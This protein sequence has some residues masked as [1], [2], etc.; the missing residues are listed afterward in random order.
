MTIDVGQW[1]IGQANQNHMFSVVFWNPKDHSFQISGKIFYNNI[2]AFQMQEDMHESTRVWEYQ[3]LILS[4]SIRSII[5]PKS[6]EHFKLE[7]LSASN[8][9]FRRPN[10]YPFSCLFGTLRMIKLCQSSSNVTSTL[11]SI[12]QE[13]K[14]SPLSSGH[15]FV[16]R[17]IVE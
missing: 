4:V 17:A 7:R 5:W 8:I 13:S 14:S 11:G 2:W 12:S 15:L 9:G 1:E 3:K 16:T 10:S 6:R